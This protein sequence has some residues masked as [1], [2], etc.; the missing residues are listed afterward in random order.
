MALLDSEVQRL[1]AELGYNALSFGAEPYIGTT[2]LFEQ[3][4]KPY[5]LA[6]AVTTSATTVAA[7][8]SPS[9]VTLTLASATGFDAL[10]R[11]VVDVDDSQ[12]IATV[13]AISGASISVFLSFAH[14]GTYPVTVEGGESM[15]REYLGHCRRVRSLMATSRGT[16]APKTVDEIALYQS[17]G[18]N[19][20]QVA[21]L[22]GELEYWR[23]ELAKLLGV[24]RLNAASRGGGGSSLY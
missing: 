9:L 20:T 14:A 13:R 19:R 18:A 12:E 22:A 3:I 7:S 5:L 24:R 1:K 4:I 15:V 17:G 11:V 8:T 10:A 2:A 21:T 6:G 16:G 23:D